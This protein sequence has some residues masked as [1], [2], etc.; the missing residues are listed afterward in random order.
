M[1][2]IENWIWKNKKKEAIVIANSFVFS[3]HK[4]FKIFSNGKKRSCVSLYR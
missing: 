1:A 2:Y 4:P 3:Q